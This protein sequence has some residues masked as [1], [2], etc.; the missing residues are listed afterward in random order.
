[1][2]VQKWIAEKIDSILGEKKKYNAFCALTS[3]HFAE[4]SNKVNNSAL[5]AYV[6]PEELEWCT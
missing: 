1:M 5:N 3:L 2:P 4:H 6:M